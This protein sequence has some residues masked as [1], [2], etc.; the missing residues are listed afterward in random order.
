MDPTSGP[1]TAVGT[2]IAAH[3]ATGSVESPNPTGATSTS[4]K[5]DWLTAEVTQT[6]VPQDSTSSTSQNED[7]NP[8]V[9][10]NEADIGSDDAG[11]RTP[12]TSN[13]ARSKSPSSR[14]SRSS[15]TS[16]SSSKPRESPPK[17]SKSP[18]VKPGTSTCCGQE[19]Q[20]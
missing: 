14:D 2:S 11:R 9:T 19:V 13:P 5:T 7:I 4:G 15:N 12:Q 16:K 1:S 18:S 17:D 3:R 20:R 10:S 8:K 6:A